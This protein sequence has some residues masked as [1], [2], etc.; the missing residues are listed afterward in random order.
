MRQGQGRQ[1][2]PP[3]RDRRRSPRGCAC[4]SCARE[5]HLVPDMIPRASFIMRCRVMNVEADRENAPM[6]IQ[7]RSK[8]NFRNEG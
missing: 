7:I 5:P 2:Q 4:K 6:R 3:S 8:T 1:R